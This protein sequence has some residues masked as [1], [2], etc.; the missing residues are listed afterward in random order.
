MDDCVA[1]R[2]ARGEG[3]GVLLPHRPRDVEEAGD[4]EEQ[5]GQRERELDEGLA[6]LVAVEDAP[7][8]VQTNLRIFVVRSSRNVFGTNG[9]L[10][11]VRAVYWTRTCA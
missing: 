7:E 4:D 2:F 5:D 11:M 10:T 9:Q 6:S 3:E 1:G 8:E